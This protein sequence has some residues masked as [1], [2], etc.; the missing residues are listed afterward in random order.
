M[1]LLLIS[2]DVGNPLLNSDFKYSKYLS[3]E[4]SAFLFFCCLAAAR[5]TLSLISKT[6]ALAVAVLMVSLMSNGVSVIIFNTR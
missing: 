1:N 4:V 6:V 3:T 2:V 5:I